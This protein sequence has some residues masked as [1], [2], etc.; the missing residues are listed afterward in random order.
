MTG[1]LLV[2]ALAV[3]L[4]CRGN[5]NGNSDSSDSVH[6]GLECYSC[7]KVSPPVLCAKSADREHPPC[8]VPFGKSNRMRCESEEDNCIAITYV[9]VGTVLN[10]FGCDTC[11]SIHDKVPT[12]KCV[13][14]K[15]NLCNT[16]APTSCDIV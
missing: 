11:E 3:A 6:T 5:E 4:P 15:Q 10:L 8:K 13:E 14:C 16:E 7:V 2:F 12:A 1:Y 9:H